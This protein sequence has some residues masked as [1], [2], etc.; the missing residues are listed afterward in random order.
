MLRLSNFAVAF[1]AHFAKV[2]TTN[3]GIGCPVK[4][5]RAVIAVAIILLVVAT[6]KALLPQNWEVALADAFLSLAN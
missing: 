3:Q 1:S 2:I 4:T 6:V 5:I